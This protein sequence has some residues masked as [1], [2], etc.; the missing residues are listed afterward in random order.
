M[1]LLVALIPPAKESRKYWISAFL[2]MGIAGIALTAW[3]T[4]RAGEAQEQAN[5]EVHQAQVAATTANTAATN[6]NAAA[7]DASRSATD[8]Q[9]ETKAARHEA[10]QAQQA[11]FAQQREMIESFNGHLLPGHSMPAL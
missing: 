7:T 5:R 4:K 6:A 2:F 11:L 8:A 3:L 1:G 10:H 9:E